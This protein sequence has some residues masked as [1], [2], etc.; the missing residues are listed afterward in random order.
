MLR[1]AIV[2]GLTAVLMAT[3]LTTL[4]TS[5]T[6]A[7]GPE[8]IS[9]APT[10]DNSGSMAD[11]DPGNL[12]FA[13]ARQLID[14]LESGDEITVITFADEST[15]LIPLTKVTDEESKTLIKERLTPAAPRGNTNMGSGLQDGLAQ[16]EQA[17]ASMMSAANADSLTSCITVTV[18]TASKGEPSTFLVYT[19]ILSSSFRSRHSPSAWT[20]LESHNSSASTSSTVIFHMAITLS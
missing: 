15:V 20:M 5:P 6:V 7:Q 8:G 1:A 3:A 19:C 10:I 17:S 12:R 9:L 18:L 11:T 4:P 14:L 16:F 2:L 13:A